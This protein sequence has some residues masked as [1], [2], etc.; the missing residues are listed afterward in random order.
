MT[1]AKLRP[2]L[3]DHVDDILPQAVIVSCVPLAT[4]SADPTKPPN[5]VLIIADDL[6]YRVPE[7]AERAEIS[8]G[9][10]RFILTQ[11]PGNLGAIQG[12]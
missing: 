12:N 10:R 4:A 7:D 1:A 11:I 3:G 9:S 6:G 8:S 2:I 5:V